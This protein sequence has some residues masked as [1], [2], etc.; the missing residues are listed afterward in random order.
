MKK[1]IDYLRDQQ[2]NKPSTPRGAENSRA[3]NTTANPYSRGPS[4]SD[5]ESDSNDNFEDILIAGEHPASQT[6]VTIDNTFATESSMP[7]EVLPPK[8]HVSVHSDEQ[9]IAPDSN[10]PHFVTTFGNT[11]TQFD[12][13]SW[14]HDISETTR[15][16]F[17]HAERNEP[18]DIAPLYEHLSIILNQIASMPD[19]LHI[20]ELEMHQNITAVQAV[21]NNIGDLVQKSIILMLYTIKTGLLLKTHPEKLTHLVV[22]AMLHHIGM[23]MVPSEIR[24]KKGTLTESELNRIKQ[25]PQDASR[26]LKS[27]QVKEESILLAAEQSAERFDGSGPMGISGSKIAWSARLIGLLSMFESLIHFRP[28]RERLLPR[29]AISKLI[30]SHKECFDPE[31]LKTLIE[32]ISLYPVGT[33]VQLNT[34]E[35]GLVITVHNKFPLRPLIHLTMNQYGDAIPER[36][37]DLK[38]QSN[39]VIK[40][41]TYKESLEELIQKN[42]PG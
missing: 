35:I 28:Y 12:T 4:Q 30:N 14:L 25:A 3:D 19:E 6:S 22:A 32:A 8:T 34:G 38:H 24:R 18:T 2:G 27:C 26:Y 33:Y 42:R 15:E 1:Y 17:H 29:E 16:I 5:L 23:V 20:L 40:K 11:N 39:M 21:D 37:I 10:E 7:E 9:L 13:S 41:C 31:M 36:T